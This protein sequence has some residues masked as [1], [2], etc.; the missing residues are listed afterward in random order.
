M[1]H[2][3]F[4]TGCLE[5]LDGE[6]AGEFFF[7]SFFDEVVA[8]DIAVQRCAEEGMT[9]AR[10]SERVEQELLNIFLPDGPL[11]QGIWI[12]K[13]QSLVLEMLPVLLFTLNCRGSRER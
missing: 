13:V 6:L 4:V 3:E 5:E 11:T 2:Q 1:K 12:G 7:F 8:F 10:I 9:L